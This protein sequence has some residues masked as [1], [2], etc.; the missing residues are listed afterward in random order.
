MSEN[1]ETVT[2]TLEKYEN[3]KSQI[4]NLKKENEEKTIYKTVDYTHYGHISFC[5]LF[6]IFMFLDC[7]R[8]I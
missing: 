4:V 7:L 6:L 2:I 8:I 5:V 3:M 1:I